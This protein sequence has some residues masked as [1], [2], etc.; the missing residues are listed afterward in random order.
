MTGE[1]VGIRPV[2]EKHTTTQDFVLRLNELS[3]GITDAQR[4]QSPSAKERAAF[5]R[6]ESVRTIDMQVGLLLA[7]VTD[8]LLAMEP[9]VRARESSYAAY[10]LGRVALEAAAKLAFLLDTGINADERVGRSLGLRSSTV[11]EQRKLAGAVL[12]QPVVEAADARLGELGVVA[13]SL[14][15]R[16]VRRVDNTVKWA[17]EE[18]PAATALVLTLTKDP[19]IYREL[20]GV[21]HGDMNTLRQLGFEFTGEGASGGVRVEP[22]VRHPEQEA[23]LLL[24]TWAYSVVAWMALIRKGAEQAVVAAVLEEAFNRIGLGEERGTRFWRG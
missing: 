15:L 4:A 22:V 7:S 1:T 14:G 6:E 2:G 20:S 17:G 8:H 18:I 21:V 3:E 10:T 11:S 5:V 24:V 13:E 16:V 12:D 19:A 9:V 23:L